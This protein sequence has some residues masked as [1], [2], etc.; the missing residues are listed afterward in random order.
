MCAGFRGVFRGQNRAGVLAGEGRHVG[1][2]N[3][4]V[5]QAGLRKEPG[6]VTAGGRNTYD[7]E[8]DIREESFHVAGD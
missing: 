8:G 4:D 1:V 3:L 7:A 5:H 6:L 2:C